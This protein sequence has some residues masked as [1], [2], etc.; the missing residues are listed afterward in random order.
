MSLGI[1]FLLIA[2]VLGV[3]LIGLI[4]WLLSRQRARDEGEAT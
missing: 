2:V 4:V 1:L 3:V